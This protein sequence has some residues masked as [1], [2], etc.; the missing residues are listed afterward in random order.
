MEKPSHQSR[1]VDFLDFD[2][3]GSQASTL[4]AINAWLSENPEKQ[5]ISIETLT[6]VVGGYSY[7]DRF[8]A[9]V[10]HYTTAQT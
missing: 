3:A 1:V 9:R 5:I 4:H 2:Q 7:A 8:S 6:P 10:W